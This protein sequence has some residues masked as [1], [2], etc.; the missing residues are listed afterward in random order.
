MKRRIAMGAGGLAIAY[1]AALSWLRAAPGPSTPPAS[2]TRAAA[3][4]QNSKPLVTFHYLNAI[5]VDDWRITIDGDGTLDSVDDPS[6]GP[7]HEGNV[8]FRHGRLTP[9]QM[10]K[11]SRALQ[12]AVAQ[13]KP[14]ERFHGY[15]AIVSI[16]YAGK[17]FEA[18]G[19]PR[20]DDV[21]AMIVKL[22]ESVPRV[23]TSPSEK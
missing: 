9:A 6:F 18:L 3:S 7:V 11:L 17:S 10:K 2:S 5:I 1:L 13:P 8:T 22:S 4:T 16:D 14:P 15:D 19:D 20:F 21:R 12:K 23:T